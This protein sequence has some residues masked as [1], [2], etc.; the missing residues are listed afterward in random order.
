M[1]AGAAAWAVMT[2]P[3]PEAPL[4][5]SNRSPVRV[6]GPASPLAFTAKTFE[7]SYALEPKNGSATPAAF[8]AKAFEVAYAQMQ[9][10]MEPGFSLGVP[11][12]PL[13]QSAPMPASFAWGAAEP[14]RA[15]AIVLASVPAPAVADA[16]DD[17][18]DPEA[19]TVIAKAAPLP[20]PRPSEFRL[21]V[22]GGPRIAMEAPRRRGVPAVAQAAPADDRNFFEKLFG[23]QP[24]QNNGPQLA[25]A[26]PQ[27]ELLMRGPL[28]RV[29]PAPST[30]TAGTAIYDIASRTVHL[31]SGEK[32]EAHSGLGDRKD[33]IR[34][35]RERMKGPTPP[36]TYDL[37]LRETLFHGVQAIR[38]T[39]VGGTAAI[40]GRDGLLAHTFMLGPGGDS[41]GCVSIRDYD[42]FLQAFMR[43]EIKRLVVVA[44]L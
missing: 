42:R 38:L 37:T 24:K 7:D 29:T 18:E 25:Y 1:T 13:A 23:S 12:K 41:N 43:G 40:Y 3:A 16:E 9:P 28:Q 10:L 27:D 2:A 6:N 21:P 34:Y 26:A 36:H 32:L 39:P 22:P 4:T 11:A 5:T 15:P 33:D 14:S 17:P 19:E 31:P 8:T 20:L 44:S 35:V 30:A